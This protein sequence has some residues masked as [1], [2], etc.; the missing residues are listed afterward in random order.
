M[1]IGFVA[2]RLASL[3]AFAA[4]MVGAPAAAEDADYDSFGAFLEEFR[5]ETGTPAISAVIVRDGGIAW[6]TY[7]G[8][9]D[10]EGELPTRAETTYKI[11]SVTKPIAASAILAE[12]AAGGIDLAIPM[13]SDQGWT[14]LCEFFVTT[15]IP[16]MAGGKDRHGNAIAPMACSKPSTLRDML[17]M[18]VNGDAFVYNP[19]AFARIDRAISGAGDGI[20]ARSCA[21]GSR[22]LPA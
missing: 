12:A 17:D 15:G 11:A 7:L 19:I 20:C 9:Y 8:T 18:R 5:R 14:D 13:T 21:T 6:E 1:K 10:D 3:A 16:F 2:R 22:T 4:A